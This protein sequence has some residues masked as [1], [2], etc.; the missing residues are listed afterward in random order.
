MR[1][2]PSSVLLDPAFTVPQAPPADRGVAWLRGAVA[3]FGEGEAHARRR[4]LVEEVLRD[5]VVDPAPGEDPTVALLRALG[6]GPGR[7][8]D[9]DTVARSYQPHAEQTAEADD[10]VER[11]VATLGGTHDEAAA[12]RIVVLVQAHAATAALVDQLRSGAAGPPVPTTRRIGPDGVEVEVDLTDAP[13]GA[14]PHACP[15]RELAHRLAVAAL[16]LPPA[17]PPLSLGADA[18]D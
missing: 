17:L 15:G 10:A 6:L 9:V 7:A 18:G 5:L 13:F 12:A 14:G 16:L 1:R 11:L 8:A 2:L 3:R 4:A